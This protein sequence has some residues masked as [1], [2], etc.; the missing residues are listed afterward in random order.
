MHFLPAFQSHLLQMWSKAITTSLAVFGIM[1]LYIYTLEGTLGTLQTI[2]KVVSGTAAIMIG[3]SLGLSS[4]SYYIGVLRRQLPKRR[5]F[6]L[7]GFFLATVYS[8]MMLFINPDRYFYGFFDNLFTAD[9][10]LG[11]SAMVIFGFMALISNNRAVRMLGA[12][13]WRNYLRF[14]YLAY[15]LLVVRGYILEHELWAQWFST[16]DSLPPPRL[17]VSVLA[18]L[19][20]S[21]RLS[22]IVSK[23]IKRQTPLQPISERQEAS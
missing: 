15:F 12:V 4:I 19:I 23:M 18:M 2:S 7:M 17:V 8:V 6:G 10:L 1:S 14:G 13:R 21:L 22:M 5:Y 11:L 9:L 16:L 20:F 3:L